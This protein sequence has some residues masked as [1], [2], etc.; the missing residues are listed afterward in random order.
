MTGDALDCNSS[1]YDS[2]DKIDRFRE[3]YEIN[4]FIDDEEILD[5]P[6]AVEAVEA[7]SSSDGEADYKNE[8]LKLRAELYAMRREKEELEI[9]LGI[10]PRPMDLEELNTL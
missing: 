6:E 3:D 10:S 2:Q 1:A 4:S 9:R 5:S 7:G 8:C